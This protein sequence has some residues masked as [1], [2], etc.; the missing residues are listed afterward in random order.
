[1]TLDEDSAEPATL[2]QQELADAKRDPRLD[3]GREAMIA[4]W[5]TAMRAAERTRKLGIWGLHAL[6][7][8]LER[9]ETRLGFR[10]GQSGTPV[11]IAPVLDAA[12][13]RVA[14]ARA[15]QCNE[16]AE[17]NAMTLVAMVSALDAMSSNSSLAPKKC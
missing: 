5:W 1:M 16:A 8:S 4:D 17:L 12:W 9:E 7:F 3:R 6:T 11:Q 2:A 15:E 14:L 10:R 13:E